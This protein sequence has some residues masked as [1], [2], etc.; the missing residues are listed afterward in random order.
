MGNSLVDHP[1]HYN[2][3]GVETIDLIKGSMYYQEY[4]GFLKGNIIKYISRSEYKN[5]EL[6]DLKKAQW[7][8]T[9][10]IEEVTKETSNN[11]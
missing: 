6:L 7:Y 2:Q 11:K 4:K 1:Q 8:L 3:N 5:S 10:L 9:K